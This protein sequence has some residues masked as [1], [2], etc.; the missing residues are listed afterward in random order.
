MTL[1]NNHSRQDIIDQFDADTRYVNSKDY[2]ELMEKYRSAKRLIKKNARQNNDYQSIIKNACALIDSNGDV[3]GDIFFSVPHR[4]LENIDN[5]V[6]GLTPEHAKIEYSS[7]LDGMQSL[8]EYEIQNFDYEFTKHQLEGLVINSTKAIQ[9]IPKDIRVRTQVMTNANALY[10]KLK[11]FMESFDI[12][13]THHELRSI[14]E[15]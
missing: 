11:E 10:F 1:V 4:L 5:L 6:R 3:D 2:D 7:V 8:I 15:G 12:Y 13:T 14:L 9:C